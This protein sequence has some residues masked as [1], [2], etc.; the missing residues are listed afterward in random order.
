MEGNLL[1]TQT[2]NF[3][4]VIIVDSHSLHLNTHPYHYAYQTPPKKVLTA[5]GF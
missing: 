2:N 1:L 3:H 4:R 5:K